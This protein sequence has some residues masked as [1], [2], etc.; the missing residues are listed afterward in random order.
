MSEGSKM[1]KLAHDTVVERGKVYG[2]AK[3]NME[4]T[5]TMWGEVLKT[6]VTGAEVALCMIQ[7]KIARLI[8]T[9]NHIDSIVDIA[10]YAAVLRDCVEEENET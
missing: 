8:E 9:P 7:A 2:N 3:E 10:G 6:K 5:A 1:L 4:R